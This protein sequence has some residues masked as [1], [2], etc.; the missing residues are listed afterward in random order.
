M[1]LEA[2]VKPASDHVEQLRMLAEDHLTGRLATPASPLRAALQRDDRA[3]GVALDGL[4][5][6]PA[7]S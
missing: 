5:G 1:V 3:L 2:L 6:T 7:E 4:A